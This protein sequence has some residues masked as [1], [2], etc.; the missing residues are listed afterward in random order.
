[1]EHMLS[2]LQCN[3][4]EEIKLYTNE[5]TKHTKGLVNE[6]VKKI[7]AKKKK[8]KKRQ[9]KGENVSKILCS[10]SMMP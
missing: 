9:E 4:Q 8:L 6:M 3:F 2:D 10:R 7:D 1:M 5:C